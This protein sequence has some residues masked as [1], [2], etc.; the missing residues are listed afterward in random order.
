MAV[1]VSPLVCETGAGWLAG[2]WHSGQ[3]QTL[4]VLGG[5]QIGE[6]FLGSDSYWRCLYAVRLYRQWHYQRVI[7]SGGLPEGATGM[8]LAG[9]MR[10]F[11]VAYGVPAGRIEMESRSRS[12]RENALMVT[13]MLPNTPAPAVLLT[14][15]YH[16]FR[17]SR[18][19]SKAGATVTG[20]WFPDVA[21]RA[22]SPL[23]RWSGF[24]D[25]AVETVKIGYYAAKGWM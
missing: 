15:D 17:A 23:Q 12:T 1:T 20:C 7:V 3:G 16:L 4:V 10:D 2:K 5:S 14:S 25:L 6:D 19:F 13:P 22:G 18:A 9:R 8:P 21:K 11:L 24:L